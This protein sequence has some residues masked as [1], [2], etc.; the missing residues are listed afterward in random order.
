MGGARVEK[1]PLC[2]LLCAVAPAEAAAV[3]GVESKRRQRITPIIGDSRLFC[4]A[5]E[6]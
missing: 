6:A 4:G 5:S 1:K 2:A 3:F